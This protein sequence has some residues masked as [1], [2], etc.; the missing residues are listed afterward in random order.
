M[1][2]ALGSRF[3]RAWLSSRSV[4]EYKMPDSLQ[5]FNDSPKFEKYRENFTKNAVHT[6]L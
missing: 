5:R 1:S 2:G 3:L 6:A 4:I